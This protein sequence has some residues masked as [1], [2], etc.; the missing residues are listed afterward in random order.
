MHIPKTYLSLH[1][2]TGLK[3]AA[4]HALDSS[5]VLTVDSP[6][7]AMQISL[8]LRPLLTGDQVRLLAD[9]MAQVLS[10]GMRTAEP[11]AI[12][13]EEK[14]AYAAE[15]EYWDRLKADLDRGLITPLTIV[16]AAE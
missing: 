6:H 8:Y 9:A 15:N 5:L 4:G 1:D 14:A 2:I 12:P 7:G 11:A 3:A 13:P 16:K 10:A